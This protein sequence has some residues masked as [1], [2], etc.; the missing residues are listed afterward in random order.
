MYKMTKWVCIVYSAAG[1]EAGTAPGSCLAAWDAFKTARGEGDTRL[2]YVGPAAADWAPE[3]VASADPLRDALR[4]AAECSDDCIVH[5]TPATMH[6][7]LGSFERVFA[8]LTFVQMA[9]GYDDPLKY[10][11]GG[12]WSM[13]EADC[14][15]V[16]SHVYFSPSAGHVRTT[17]VSPVLCVAAFASTMRVIYEDVGVILPDDVEVPASEVPV[18]VFL[19]AR[20]VRKFMLG[21]CL[22][23]VCRPA[24]VLGPGAGETGRGGVA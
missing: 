16:P 4:V 10:R 18:R 24:A 21:C 17:A 6:Y 3:S 11:R 22:P 15:L 14:E 5:V 23:G 19:H 1:T 12:D 13:Q 9:T 2:V 20:A 8:A 7:D